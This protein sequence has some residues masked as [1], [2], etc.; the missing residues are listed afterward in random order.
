M[1]RPKLVRLEKK[2]GAIYKLQV[3]KMLKMF[4]FKKKKV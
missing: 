2:N 4:F 1:V 3:K